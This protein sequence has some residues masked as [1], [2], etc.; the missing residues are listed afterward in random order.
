MET[1]S[2]L[3]DICA[4]NSPVAGEFPAQRPVTRSFDIFFDLRPN[5]RLNKQSLGWWFE[6]PSRSLW[7]QCKENHF[8]KYNSS[9]HNDS[10][11]YL[12]TTLRSNADQTQSGHVFVEVYV[13]HQWFD[14]ACCWPDDVIQN[15]W[16]DHFNKKNN[17]FNSFLMLKEHIYVC[18]PHEI[19]HTQ[20]YSSGLSIN[21]HS[22]VQTMPIEHAIVFFR[23]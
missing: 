10:I 4:G 16:H 20:N 23:W 7:R 1:F 6:T 17:S 11:S 3:L 15:G 18:S 21:W 13:N 2:A 19:F 12:Q 9:I 14:V 8:L 22:M 5:K